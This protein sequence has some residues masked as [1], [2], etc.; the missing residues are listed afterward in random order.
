[1]VS[2]DTLGMV[3]AVL[4]LY[5]PP[6]TSSGRPTTVRARIPLQFN[7]DHLQ[8]TKSASWSRTP[9]SDVASASLP[10]FRGADPRTLSVE[11]FLD[12][13]FPAS[14]G[15]EKQVEQLIG[16]CGPTA[17]SVRGHH[18]A[19]P[20]VQLQWGQSKTVSF[21]AFVSHLSVDYMRFGRNGAPTR[22]KCALSMEEIGGAT[23]RQN[24]T[25]RAD[26]AMRTHRWR[27]RDHLATLAWLEYGD[28]GMWRAIAVTNNIADPAAIT[29]GTL[30]T[31]PAFD[32][33][34]DPSGT[35]NG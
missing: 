28:P 26:G 32:Q 7:P 35:D 8:M 22:A 23:P 29:A 12:A 34:W 15:V 5:E 3:H 6:L 1:M 25:S 19:P 14:A 31:L 11:V 9:Y 17:A 20:W 13:S 33:P 2:L 30:L 18:A 10:E 24:P 21:F 27:H 16:C 4:V